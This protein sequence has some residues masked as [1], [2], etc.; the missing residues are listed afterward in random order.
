MIEEGGIASEGG[1]AIRRLERI[2]RETMHQHN[3]EESVRELLR[4]ISYHRTLLAQLI[5]LV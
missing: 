3:Q 1:G 5:A 4:T 2:A